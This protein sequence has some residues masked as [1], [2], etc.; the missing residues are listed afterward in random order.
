MGP[1]Y[2]YFTNLKT[3]LCL[4]E[5]NSISTLTPRLATPVLLLHSSQLVG[6]QRVW[7]EPLVVQQLGSAWSERTS[8]EEGGGS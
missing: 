5:L 1:L 6:P 7:V 3:F 4:I 8:L 2:F